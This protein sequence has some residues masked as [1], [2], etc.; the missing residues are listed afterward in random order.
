YTISNRLHFVSVDFE[1]ST[2]WKELLNAGFDTHKKAFVSCTGVT[3]Y[4]TREAIVD[5]LKKMTLL[6]SDSVI[7][8]A[9]YLPLAQL[10][11]GDQSMQEMAIK[12]AAASGTPFVSFFT[13]EEIT[14]LANEI[15]LKEIQIV[16]TKNMTEKYFK[17]RT[18][19]LV[20][21]SGEF[22]L[23]AKI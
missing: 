19:K 18:D 5:T 21:A 6:A 16:S 17:N 4:L 1:T 7:A 10:D 23:V 3:L 20:P 11:E 13:Y 8:V 14:K 22:F 2:W 9:F 15:G 12:G